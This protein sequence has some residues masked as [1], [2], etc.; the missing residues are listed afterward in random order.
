LV[1]TGLGARQRFQN[2][3]SSRE[4]ALQTTA[5]STHPPA[6][7]RRSTANPA[8]ETTKKSPSTY[9]P[10]GCGAEKMGLDPEIDVLTSFILEQERQNF[11]SD[12]QN[13]A[14]SLTI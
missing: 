9:R 13:F 10:P 14:T 3:G 2:F 4:N 11:C 1:R 6:K 8:D 12:N 7:N 5:K